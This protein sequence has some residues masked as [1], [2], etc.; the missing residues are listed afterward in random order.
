LSIDSIFVPAWNNLGFLYFTLARYKEAER[1]LK[2][3]NA[4]DTNFA[5]PYKLLGMV[6]FKTGR[7]VEA[8]QN[9]LHALELNPNYT[10]A[11]LGMA[12][13]GSAVGKPKEAMSYV[14][15]ATGK[16]ATLEQLSKDEDLVQLRSTQEWKI[17][18]KKYFADTFK[19]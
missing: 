15:Q 19:D 18:M 8:R 13:L 4:L 6:H 2:I 9:F 16:G 10:G 5:T 11:I 14:E 1:V 7:L 17:L 3:A 12:Y